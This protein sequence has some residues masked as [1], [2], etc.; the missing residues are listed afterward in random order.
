MWGFAEMAFGIV[1]SCLPI[2]PR[3]YQHISA[4]TPYAK[5]Q[6]NTTL[7]G[8]S[9]RDSISPAAQQAIERNKGSNGGNWIH[10]DDRDVP[11]MPERT[12]VDVQQRTKDEDTLEEAVEAKERRPRPDEENGIW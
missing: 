12:T 1:C 5:G 7:V 8:P 10:L 3:F 6:H 4:V 9:A 2:L 11:E